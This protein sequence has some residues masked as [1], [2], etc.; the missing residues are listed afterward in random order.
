MHSGRLTER[1]S[2]PLPLPLPLLLLLTGSLV[3]QPPGSPADGVLPP[4]LRPP[5][6]WL[7]SQPLLAA[8]TDVRDEYHSLKDPSIVFYQNAWHLFGTVR[9][10]K[11]THQIEYL[12]FTRLDAADRAD[13]AFLKV[14]HGFYCAPQVFYF[15]PQQKW[16]LI[17]QASDPEWHPEY[18]PAFSTN[19]NL[20]DV[21]GWERLVPLEHRRSPANAEL[22]FWVICDDQKAHLFFTSLD[23]RMW[24]EETRLQDFPRGWSEPV[25]A[26][27]ADVFEASHTYKVRQCDLYLTLIEAQHPQGGRYYQAYLADRLDRPWRPLAADVEQSFA[28][29]Q[30][31]HFTG[32]RWTDWI[33]HGELLRAGYDER[34][35]I[36][37][38]SLKFIFQGVTAPEAAGRPYGA[39]PWRL[40][41]LTQPLRE[42]AED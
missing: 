27:E 8:P 37:G 6:R 20:A 22:D 32:A 11:R 21:D 42:R 29:P 3:A 7:A 24:R 14:H 15:R 19:T 31:V 28:G 41:L 2:L 10:L 16:Y 39:I 26:L 30:N 35:E 17:C 18:G 13:R 36:D 38:N 40:G 25:V 1:S 33:S 9:A 12:R 4:G 34:L 23:G 5:F